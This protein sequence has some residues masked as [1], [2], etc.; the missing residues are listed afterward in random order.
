[1]IVARAVLLALAAAG[2]AVVCACEPHE[3]DCNDDVDDDHDGLVDCADP[4]CFLDVVCTPCGDG[5]LDADEA[6]DDGN[7]KD[8]DGCSSR[9]TLETCG[10]G[11][12]DPGE[13]CDDRNVRNG[14][15]CN[16]RC[17]F[18]PCGNGLLDAGEQC[19]D[20]ND[21]DGDGCSSS[22]TAETG[23][24]ELCGNFAFDPGEQCDDGNQ[25]DGDGCNHV[26]H[27]EFC[28]DNVRQPRLG[29]QCDGVDTPPGQTCLGC[30]LL[31]CGNGIVEPEAGEECDDGNQIF[32]DGCTNCRRDRCGDGSLSVGEDCDD[33]NTLSG[34]GC[35]STCRREFCGDG[36]VQPRLGELC[37]TGDG[38]DDPD[39]VACAP[40]HACAADDVCYGISHQSTPVLASAAV[41][42][43]AQGGQPPRALL[44]S[45][46]TSLFAYDIDPSRPEDALTGGTFFGG[47]VVTVLLVVDGDVYAGTLDGLVGRFDP[48]GNLTP[49]L[50]LFTRVVDLAA[51][52]VGATAAQDVVAVAAGQAIGVIFDGTHTVHGTTPF[53]A[54]RVAVAA[55]TIVVAGGTHLCALHADA[56][57]GAIDAD[58]PVEVP[59]PATV[60]DVAAVDVDADGV[61]DL[62]VL[63]NAPDALLVYPNAD[64]TA[65]QQTLAS[66]PGASRLT[67]AD[68]DGDGAGD[69]VT[70]GDAAIVV[71]LARDAFAAST[72]LPAV[73]HGSRVDARDVDGDG[74]VDL[75]VVGGVFTSNV[76]LFLGE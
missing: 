53:E 21:R 13:Q 27:A 65:A 70:A 63:A 7:N 55:G 24:P 32:G 38:G 10:N 18:D 9:C 52:D 47:S 1:M 71:H 26:C 16:F 48:F 74:D 62:V 37:D 49:T 58:A 11:V 64:L 29:E 46:Q 22:C 59:A 25:V 30:Q 60:A 35:S 50:S 20:G 45:T 34:D 36:V 68:V 43:P 72:A 76:L 17:R 8:G 12:V 14:D 39:C 41:L 2:V 61:V 54:E 75:V 57:A 67:A 56:D 40:V 73:Q 15:G 66:A 69:L 4:D 33:F 31:R 42:V 44:A 28:G 51:G 23:A 5:H 3:S 19:D 6:C